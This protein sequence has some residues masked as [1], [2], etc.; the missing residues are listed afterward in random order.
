MNIIQIKNHL[1]R[2][3]NVLL[4]NRNVSI[5]YPPLKDDFSCIL[6]GEPLPLKFKIIKCIQR[7]SGDDYAS[8]EKMNI[9]QL[10]D[11]LLSK[12]ENFKLIIIFNQFDRLTRKSADIYMSLSQ[13][14]KVVYLS[15]FQSSFKPEVYGFYQSF[16]L[17]NKDE[18]ESQTGKNDINIS[19]A[20]YTILGMVCFLVYLKISSSA[21]MSSVLIGA[22]WFGLIIFRTLIY[23]GGR[24]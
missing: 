13:T 20:V 17:I 7:V 2:G 16:Q 24:V 21:A 5:C 9:V 6:L 11:T 4:Y 19:Y 18:Y 3:E 22:V 8:L 10:R 15:S 14:G 1:L 12:L 23:V